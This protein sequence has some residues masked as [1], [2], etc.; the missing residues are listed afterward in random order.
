MS[1]K[2]TIPKI[3]L[4]SLPDMQMC[5]NEHKEISIHRGVV[6]VWDE[7]HDSR[8]LDWI[9][10]QPPVVISELIAVQEHEGSIC[11]AWAS[12]PPIGYREG[13]GGFNVRDGDSWSI[14]ESARYF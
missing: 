13:D 14:Y 9:D 1:Y 8:I 11:M 2:N 3:R 6:V 5:L 7:D 4:S 12:D 10:D